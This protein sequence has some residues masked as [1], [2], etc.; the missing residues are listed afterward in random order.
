MAKLGGPTCGNNF[1]TED[2]GRGLLPR[3]GEVANAYLWRSGQVRGHCVLIHRCG[4]V[5]EPAQLPE[6][7]AAAFWRDALT[8]GHA[9]EALYQPL[10]INYLTLGNKIP[11]LH[12]HVFAR[13]TAEADPVPGGPLPFAALDEGRQDEQ[14]LQRDATRL[15][16]LLASP[17]T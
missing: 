12:S 14:Q 1:D 11:Q 2:I 6:P 4:H 8:L 13:R 16:L 10:K 17:A 3:R 15:R 7:E 9:I 5:A